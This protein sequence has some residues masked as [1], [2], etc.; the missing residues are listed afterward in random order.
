MKRNA[1]KLFVALALL[2]AAACAPAAPKPGPPTGDDVTK[3][4]A[5]RDGFLAAFNAGDAA[6]IVE[7]Y[8]PDAIAMPSHHAMVSGR[9]AILAFNRDFFSQMSATMSLTPQETTVSWDLGYD[10]GTFSMTMTPKA[11]GAP[12]S[13]HGKYLV[14]LQRQSDGSWKVTRDIDNSD[15][16]MPPPPPP[17]APEPAKGK[18]RGK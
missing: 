9:D 11:G 7:S 13:D 5:L 14:V 1:R 17:P 4:N 10:R 3:I 8:T 6:K 15:M 18:G 12:M 2:G 16:P